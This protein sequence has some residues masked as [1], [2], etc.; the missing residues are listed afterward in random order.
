MCWHFT[1]V[2]LFVCF[3]LPS[4]IGIL[5]PYLFTCCLPHCSSTHRGSAHLSFQG[6]YF[7]RPVSTHHLRFE[8]IP[9][10]S[11]ECSGKPAH[12]CSIVKYLA[13]QTHT[14]SKPREEQRCSIGRML[15]LMFSRI[16]LELNVASSRPTSGTV[17]YPWARHCILC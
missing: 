9:I 7:K 3:R 17:L 8:T 1:F 2:C 12:P 10:R 16:F 13:V 5:I 15:D 6:C 11:S 4:D 14:I